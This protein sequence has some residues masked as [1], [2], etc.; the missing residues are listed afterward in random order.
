[1]LCTTLCPVQATKSSKHA[2]TS[3]GDQLHLPTCHHVIQNLCDPHLVQDLREEICGVLLARHAH[4]LHDACTM[5]LLQKQASQL[6]VFAMKRSS[7]FYCQ[8]RCVTVRAQDDWKSASKY[9]FQQRLQS[10]SFLARRD[11]SVV[12]SLHRTQSYR[13][14]SST[15]SVY[16]C[17]G[18]FLL[19]AAGLQ[20]QNS[21]SLLSLCE[22]S[23]RRALLSANKVLSDDS[24]G[25]LANNSP[26]VALVFAMSF[27]TKRLFTPV[28]L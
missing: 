19:L 8:P 22:A 21:M 18:L 13:T 1:M 5:T 10:S 3:I 24:V 27:S 28:P 17:N 23:C 2:V 25:V 16:C 26:V 20:Q 6:H 7:L 12:L 9:F 4:E 14:L 15:P 11:Q